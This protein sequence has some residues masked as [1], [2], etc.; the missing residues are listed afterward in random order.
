M[1]HWSRREI[2]RGLGLT[3]AGLGLGFAGAAELLAAPPAVPRGTAF[4]DWIRVQPQVPSRFSFC[5]MGDNRPNT[6]IFD[7]IAAR[8]NGLRPAFTIHLGDI[9]DDGTVKQ[10]EL[11]SPSLQAFAA[12]MIATPGNHDR[13]LAGPKGFDIR[14]WE[15]EFGPREWDFTVGGWHFVAIDTALGHVTKKQQEWLDQVLDD[16]M[17]TMVFTHYPPSID[18]WKVH[19]LYTGTTEFLALLKKHT[20]EHLFC[21]HNHLFDTMQLGPTSGVITAGA[22][23]WLYK[24]WGFG[25]LKHHVTHVEIEGA[26]ATVTMEPI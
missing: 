14:L 21:G 6:K 4:L 10:W 24:K 12:P 18:R 9:V 26:K 8:T 23:S 22:G 5:V 11:V 16:N 3:G 2:L 19:A 20:V 7:Q 17:P 13:Y 1:I 25:V 15:L